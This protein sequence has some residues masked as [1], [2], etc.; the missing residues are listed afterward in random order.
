MNQIL[1][2]LFGV[3]FLMTEPRQRRRIYSR[4][5]DQVNDAVDRASRGYEA[6]ADRI[7]DLYQ[8]AC[9]EDH[10]AFSGTTSFLIGVGVGAGFGLLIAPASGKKTRETIAGRVRGFQEDVRRSGRK[11]A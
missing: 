10:R 6:V 3:G 11:T 2:F 5:S 1:R 9:G 8:T 7:E 4:M